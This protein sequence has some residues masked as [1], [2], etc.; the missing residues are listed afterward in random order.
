ML[1]ILA[2]RALFFFIQTYQCKPVTYAAAC[3]L[4]EMA[5]IHCNFVNYPSAMI[6]SASVFV[7][8]MLTKLSPWTIE[9]QYLTGYK[10]SDIVACAFQLSCCHE[11][12]YKE[13]RDSPLMPLKDKYRCHAQY[14][15]STLVPLTSEEFKRKIQC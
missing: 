15:V 3:Y 4:S 5:I 8:R 9:L 6:A 14:Q 1:C 7:A 10:Q 12:V 11:L 2:S 13:E